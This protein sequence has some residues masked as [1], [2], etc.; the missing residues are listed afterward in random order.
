MHPGLWWW[1]AACAVAPAPLGSGSF[2]PAPGEDGAGL[3]GLNVNL[4]LGLVAFV[5]DD[6]LENRALELRPEDAWPTGCGR[7]EDGVPEQAADIE[8]APVVLPEIELVPAT[9]SG[10]CGSVGGLRLVAE[11]PPGW[12]LILEPF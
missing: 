11:E 6:G 9:L 10:Y 3:V 7:G 5:L 2:V 4:S 1:W 8:P 12:E